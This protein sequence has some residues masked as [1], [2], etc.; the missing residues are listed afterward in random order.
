MSSNDRKE[1]SCYLI[2][3]FISVIALKYKYCIEPQNNDGANHA[4]IL[5]EGLSL[6]LVENPGQSPGMG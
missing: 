1:K 5:Q 6:F 2:Q 3:L 4:T